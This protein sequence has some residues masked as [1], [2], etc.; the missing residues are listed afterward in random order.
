MVNEAQKGIE[1]TN[2]ANQMPAAKLK[3]S[4]FRGAID[5][6]NWS[7]NDLGGATRDELIRMDVK[8]RL[9]RHIAIVDGMIGR[10]PARFAADIEE[11]KKA[12]GY[13]EKYIAR[14]QALVVADAEAKAAAKAR[15]SAPQAAPIP[16]P[17]PAAKTHLYL[18]QDTGRFLR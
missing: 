17:A 3:I 18:V 13:A 16:T 7:R 12:I 14:W 2:S 5:S 10:V 11:A 8:T 15:Q 4:E 9:E 1:M 6:L